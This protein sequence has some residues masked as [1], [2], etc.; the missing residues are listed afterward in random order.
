V[1]E[2][3]L[4]D[5]PEQG[6]GDDPT[7][8]SAVAAL[9]VA[10]DTAVEVL[11]A[12]SGRQFGACPVTVRPCPEN[13][14]PSLRRRP[15]PTE[16]EVFS[17]R[18]SSWAVL[19]CGCATR[20]IRSGPGV[21]HLPGPVSSIVAVTVD[22]VELDPSEYALEEDRLYRVDGFW[23]SQ[24]MSRPVTDS[25]TWQVEYLRGIEPPAGVGKL[26]AVLATE[27]YNACTG[28]KCR[29]PRTIT[30]VTRQGVSHR[31]FNP[32]DI[33]ASGKTGIPE[34]DLWLSAV[35]PYR[36]LAAPTVL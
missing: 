19:G 5:L 11:W 12:L 13:Y 33:Y 8:A 14:P 9:S 34:I 29:L 35:N 27:F 4:P 1:D 28:G 25:G 16:Y 26:V 7:Y 21:V 17:W 20:C 6:S 3:C 23:P 15:V 36:V 31:V 18:D 24:D 10:V 22:G 32:N 30:D 2:S